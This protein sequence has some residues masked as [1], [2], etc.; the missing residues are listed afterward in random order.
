MELRQHSVVSSVGL[1]IL[2][3][4]IGVYLM[5]HGWGKLQM[6]LGGQFE[7][8]G[9]PIGVGTTLSLILALFGEF[10][11]PLLVV[12]GLFTRVAAVPPVITMAVAA[13]VVHASDP[14]TMG[15]GPSK[16]PALLYLI[17][18]LAL[19][20]TGPGRWSLDAVLWPRMLHRRASTT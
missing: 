6:L 2:R 11:C 5:T 4:G 3:V 10:V 16:E 8:L 7:Q 19:V 9:D 13:F 1:L 20:F 18:F 12:L 14:W 15:G 17:P